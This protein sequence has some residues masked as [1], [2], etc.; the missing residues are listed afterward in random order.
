MNTHSDTQAAGEPVR[1]DTKIAVL[2]REDLEPWQRL[3]VTAF[4][5]SGLGGQVPEVIGEP[6]EDADGVPYL[7]MFRQPVLVFQGAKETLTAAHAKALSRALPRAVFTSDLFATGNDRDNRAAVRAV[8]TAELDLV[9]L[10][11]YGPRNAVDKVLK[12][13]RMHP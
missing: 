3:N 11:V 13:A 9:G 2:L 5:V 6:Y 12:G 7:P 1:F 4:L 8:P 10:A